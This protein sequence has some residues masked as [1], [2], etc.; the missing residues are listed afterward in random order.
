MFQLKSDWIFNWF[1]AGIT[2]LDI[3]TPWGEWCGRYIWGICPVIFY[4]ITFSF[5]QMYFNTLCTVFV[6]YL[7]IRMSLKYIYICIYIYVYI[8]IY[9]YIRPRGTTCPVNI[10]RCLFMWATISERFSCIGRHMLALSLFYPL[11][12]HPFVV[13]SS[14]NKFHAFTY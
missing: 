3:A 12:A 9:I 8:Y 4:K 2:W 1:Q 7:A 5:T 14:I 10:Y 11:H 13:L 6:L